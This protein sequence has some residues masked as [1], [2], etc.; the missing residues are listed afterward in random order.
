MANIALTKSKH[1]LP[2]AAILTA[3]G[4]SVRRLLKKAS[5][6]VTCLDDPDTLIS[7]VCEGPFRELVAKKTGL[8]NISLDATRHLEIEDLGNFGQ[9]L[10]RQPT[11]AAALDKF[12]ELVVTD[13][14]NLSIELRPLPNGDLW[15]GQRMLSHARSG[16]WHDN[17]YIIS[18]MLKVAQLADPVWSPAEILISARATQ[19]RFEAIEM[20]GST[21]RLQQNCSGFIVPASILALPVTKTLVMGNDMDTD[22]WPSAPPVTYAESLKRMIGTYADD[23]WLNIDQAS[24]IADTSLRT[25]QRRLSTEQQTYSNLVQQ[26]RS[27]IAG[28]LLENTAASMAEIAH[29]L[30]Y[31]HQGDFT[32][33]FK[34]WAK[35]T[36]SEFRKHRSLSV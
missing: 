6:P 20:L 27:E 18:W 7:A 2:F 13:T 36:P 10:L 16:E 23:C 15:F 30:G 9:A 11:V 28:G 4:I 34:H 19:G 14:S 12:R 35:V 8:P 24:E 1:L 21:A 29:H 32:H 5:L 33:A 25:M 31:R 22:I 26:C 3:H 17:L